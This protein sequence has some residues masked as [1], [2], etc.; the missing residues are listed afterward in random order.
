MFGLA[1]IRISPSGV[2][3]WQ[4]M[5]PSASA[6]AGVALC[7]WL[8][9][10]AG[11][12]LNKSACI[13]VWEASLNPSHSSVVWLL[14]GKFPKAPCEGPLSHMGETILFQSHPSDYIKDMSTFCSFALYIPW[15]FANLP[16]YTKTLGLFHRHGVQAGCVFSASHSDHLVFVVTGY[17]IL[18]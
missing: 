6:V 17:L 2:W 4:D 13:C 7:F 15:T 10:P 3:W 14:L 8:V 16:F 18:L 12:G 11:T 9:C 1:E 5:S